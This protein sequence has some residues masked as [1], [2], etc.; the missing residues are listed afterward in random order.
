M[1]H[2]E[3]SLTGLEIGM[4]T[5]TQCTT[6]HQSLSECDP[7]TLRLTNG[8]LEACYCISCAPTTLQTGGDQLV[9]ARLGIA[10]DAQTQRTWLIP[11]APTIIATTQ[12]QPQPS[13][14][15][16]EVRE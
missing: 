8:T 7:V 11:V 6:C 2:H 1:S 10:Q 3:E 4:G 13:T 16:Q 12:V 15:T 5:T 9:E 14:Q